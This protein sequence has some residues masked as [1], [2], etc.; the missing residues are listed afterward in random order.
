MSTRS[1][2]R[3]IRPDQD[4]ASPEEPTGVA[5]VYKHSD[6]YPSAV[7]HLLVEL[8]DLLHATE[9]LRGPTY[10][11]AQFIFLDTCSVMPLYLPADD[12]L[13]ASRMMPASTPRDVVDPS[14]MHDLDQPLFL[15]GN[16]V[17]DPA[18][19][20][21]GDE[22]FLYEPEVPPGPSADLEDWAVRV[23]AYCEFPHWDGATALAFDQATWRFRGP[24][25]EA[26]VEFVQDDGDGDAL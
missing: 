18:T 23:S 5:Q 1:Q 4:D 12:D 2:L 24:P 8:A 20:I 21:Y 19:G 7:V 16:A 15:L 11:A 13:D 10:A 3:F 9:T 26:H 14:A 22:E 17:E 25:S 6:G